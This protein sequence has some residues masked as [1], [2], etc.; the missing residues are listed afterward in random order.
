MPDNLIV[1]WSG[2]AERSYFEIID[3][4]NNSW[5]EKEIQRFI[6]R[7]DSVINKIIDNP[8]LFEQHKKD[9]RIRRAVVHPTVILVYKISADNKI[10]TLLTFWGTRRNPKK[11]IS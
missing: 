4:L 5:T 6:L 10:I 11:F 3:Y 7:T 2:K 8:Q 1:V 9:P